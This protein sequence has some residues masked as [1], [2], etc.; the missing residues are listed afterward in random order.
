MTIPAKKI[1]IINCYFPEMREAIKRR[2]EVPDALAP[3]LLAGYFSRE[4][5]EIKLYNE[6]HS[7]FVEVFSPELLDWP[8]MVV[9]TGLTAAFDRLRKQ[10]PERPEYGQ[11][12]VSN[13][14]L[15][16]SALKALQ[17]AGFRAG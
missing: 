1:L 8:D 9:M 13:D 12:T 16:L 6:V 7:G 11:F 3:V 10:Y 15:Q 4:H 2:N 17:A 5:C 14:G